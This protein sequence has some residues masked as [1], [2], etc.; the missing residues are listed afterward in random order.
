ME[1]YYKA[2]NW[3]GIE[4]VIDKSTWEKLTEQFWLDTRIPLSN[5]LD[6]WRKLSNVEKRLGRKSLWWFNP[7]RHYAI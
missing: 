6:D 1:T 3:N 2:I 5:D 4:D 7:S